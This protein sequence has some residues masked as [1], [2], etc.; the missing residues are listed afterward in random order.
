MRRQF[1]KIL[2]D[3]GL[4]LASGAVEPGEARAGA[5]VVVAQTPTIAV[6]TSFIAAVGTDCRKHELQILAGPF[7]GALY[8]K[9]EIVGGW[10]EG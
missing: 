9:M 6:E 1:G 5:L 10:D 2:I 7:V 8:T 3:N 4:V